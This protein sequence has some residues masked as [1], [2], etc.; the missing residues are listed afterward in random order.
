MEGT[1]NEPQPFPFDRKRDM[2]LLDSLLIGSS[3]P[4]KPFSGEDLIQ[5]IQ[6]SRL[7]S[8]VLAPVGFK[9]PLPKKHVLSLQERRVNQKILRGVLPFLG[10]EQFLI[11]EGNT[12][13]FQPVGVIDSGTGEV[14]PIYRLSVVDSETGEE[15]KET[16]ALGK[17]IVLTSNEDDCRY[18]K[19]LSLENDRNGA[20][21]LHVMTL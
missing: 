6:E 12:I 11:P 19:Y 8:E 7:N 10:D 21:F 13:L 16:E 1:V 17:Y 3:V 18:V 2:S 5:R 20:K 14:D 4:G 9:F 15:T